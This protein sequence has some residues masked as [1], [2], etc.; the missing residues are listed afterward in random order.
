L[1]DA[2]VEMQVPRE[3]IKNW[4]YRLVGL[5]VFS[6]YVNWDDGILFSKQASEL[7]SLQSCAKC[8]GKLEM[9]GKGVIKCPYC[10]TEYFLP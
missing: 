8:G 6:G 1:S 2:A 10:G 7:R 3:E 4:V 5:G 9:A